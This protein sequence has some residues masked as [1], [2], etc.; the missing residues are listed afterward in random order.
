MKINV[1]LIS[2]LCLFQY[3]FSQPYIKKEIRMDFYYIPWRIE[4]EWPYTAKEIKKNKEST[5]FSTNDT[6]FINKLLSSISPNELRE[7]S[8]PMLDVRMLIEV[9]SCDSLLEVILVGQPSFVN[10]KV[11]WIK[12]SV[13]P[14]YPGVR[15]DNDIIIG[16]FPI[17]LGDKIYR[18]KFEF[19]K[20]LLKKVPKAKDLY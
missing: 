2:F 13:E 12:D 6:I 10:D 4:P 18:S 11:E 19:G 15:V 17:Q 5:F 1:I 9:V 16:L 7:T 3:S 20:L 14:P 8:I